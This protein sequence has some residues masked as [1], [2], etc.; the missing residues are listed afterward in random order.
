M[1]VTEGGIPE[2]LEDRGRHRRDPAD[3]DIAL[4]GTG[5]RTGDERVGHDDGLA[6]IRL[7]CLR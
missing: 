3:R 6:R 7:R 1:E 4:R 2:W 5:H